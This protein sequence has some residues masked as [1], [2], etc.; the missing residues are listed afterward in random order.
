MCEFIY[1]KSYIYISRALDIYIYIKSKLLIYIS[2]ALFQKALS[3]NPKDLCCNAN[4][5]FANHV[6]EKNALHKYAH[7]DCIYP[8]LK[9]FFL[10][11]HNL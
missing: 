4:A 5:K 7:I 1:I 9:S 6:L 11:K 10:P 3:A 8:Y 2:R